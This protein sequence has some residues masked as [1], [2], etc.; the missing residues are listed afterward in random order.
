MLRNTELQN[1]GGSDWNLG[2]SEYQSSALPL[3]P[4]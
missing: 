1:V 4:C 2:P 3:E